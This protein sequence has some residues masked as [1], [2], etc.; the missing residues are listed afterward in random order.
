MALSTFQKVAMVSGLVLCISLL[1]P[2][3][4]VSRGKPIG[5]QEGISGQFPSAL[6]QKMAE[7]RPAGS[8]Y[9]RAHLAEAMSKAKM[10]SG[11]ARHSLVGQ[12]IPIYGFGIFLYILYIL[13]K[14]SSKGKN[15]KAERKCSSSTTGNLKRKI[16]DYELSQL[17]DK[18]RET[19]E[20]MEKIISRIGANC[21]RAE[22][23]SAD[24]EQ[25][26]LEQL[27]E[28]TRVMKE[29]KL[30]DGVSPEKDAE[31]AP[32]VQDQEG[33]PEETYRLYENSDCCRGR[34]ATVLVDCSEINQPFVKELAERMEVVEDEE[35]L[36]SETAVNSN[37]IKSFR[38]E[39]DRRTIYSDQSEDLRWSQNVDKC[40]CYDH[41]DNDPAVRAENSGFSLDSCSDRDDH[42]NDGNKMEKNNKAVQRHELG[43]LRKRSRKGSEL[44]FLLLLLGSIF[45]VV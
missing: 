40:P 44:F 37:E 43:P 2:R 9:P 39:E 18:L 35:N 36:Y 28:I 24:Q 34:C 32:Y 30:F 42:L 22:P 45:S 21:E 27:N 15:N 38:D 20:V 8:P 19:E 13:F 14:L 33:Y 23:V 31:G 25:K 29:G 6:H 11:G 1:L 16:T 5:Q 26:L 10:G 41:N 3:A 7:S 12:I 17:Q 4:F